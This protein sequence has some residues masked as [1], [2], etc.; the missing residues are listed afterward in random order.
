MHTFVSNNYTQDM[1]IPQNEISAIFDMYTE[2]NLQ[3]Q[4]TTLPVECAWIVD[5]NHLCYY[6]VY[7]Q[8]ILMK[9]N[10]KKLYT[11]TR[12]TFTTRFEKYII[13]ELNV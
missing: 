9:A 10:D 5:N 6:F 4:S 11:I 3:K 1:L 13:H 7:L 12:S 2:Y 8:R